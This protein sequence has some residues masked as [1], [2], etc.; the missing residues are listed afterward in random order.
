MNPFSII[1]RS[2]AATLVIAIAT[3]A[4]DVSETRKPPTHTAASGI[5]KV[6][7][8]LDGVAESLAME[9]IKLS[10]KAWMDLTVLD[11][12][13]HG[14][15]VKKDDPL[16]RLDLEK[17]RDQIADL[18]QD[19]EPA[20]VAL[21]LAKAE[22]ENLK[23]TTPLK[24]EAAKRTQRIA[25]EDY[26]Y[27]ES[28]GRSQRQKNAQFSLKSAEQRL[29]NANEELRQL[30]KM[31]EADDLT[32]DT[33]E[34]ILKRQKF[35][36]EA[37]QLS[38]ESVRLNTERELKVFL[39][40]EHENLKNARRDQELAAT[41]ANQ[42]LPKALEKK[43]FEVDKLER[44]QRKAAKKLTDFKYDLELLNVRAPADGLVYYGACEN[45]KWTTGAAVSKKLVPG[46]KLA[47]N[48][49]FMTVVN[50]ETLQLRAV[51][52]EAELGYFR[53][54][55]KGDASP[56]S[57]PGRKLTAEVEE[58][59]VVPLPTGGFEATLSLTRDNG[60]HLVPGMNCKVSFA[61]VEKP[62]GIVVPKES[63]FSDGPQKHVYLLKAD[64][65]NE[66]RT[67]K[68]G[69]SDDKFTEITE[70]LSAGDQVL[71]KKPEQS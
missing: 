60:I 39:I 58:I 3:M 22:L 9:P 19:Q 15:R 27:F 61:E 65:S 32:E 21:A 8:Q 40:R 70:G 33:E 45:G 67:V 54:G 1:T 4:S 63:I 50:S 41:L 16:V 24:L 71:L 28:T 20:A 2:T 64:G 55:M 25:D 5:I 12:V 14:S 62:A 46:G 18:E 11:A 34:I 52:P 35:A 42:S 43:Q 23:Q 49:I 68:T 17:L 7:T 37:A 44:D 31:Y 51:I 13:K 47:A 38:L 30:Q 48:E 36:V 69:E 57:A 66:K 10:P 26:T 59:G 6:K 29:E 56:V 53:V